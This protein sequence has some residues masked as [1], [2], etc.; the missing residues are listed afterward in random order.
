VAP[1]AEQDVPEL[2]AVA[3]E[4][5]IRPLRRAESEELSAYLARAADGAPTSG[6]AELKRALTLA[7]SGK[8][9]SALKAFDRAASM[10][11][12]LA[13]WARALGA[14]AAAAVGDTALV[15]RL[16]SA[17][18]P[19]LGR[20]WGWR[21]EVV[22]RRVAGDLKGATTFAVEVSKTLDD[23]GRR[24]EAARAAGELY[25][26][27]RDTAAAMTEFRRAMEISPLSIG[28][29]DAA[30]LLAAL[31][32]VSSDD[33]GLVGRIYLRHGNIDRGL[34]YID[35]FVA[36]AGGTPSERVMSRLEAG[37]ALFG[38]GRYREVER[39]LIPLGSQAAFPAVS[40]EALVLVGRAQ[41]RLDR[42]DDARATFRSVTERLAD[43]PAAAEAFYI[44]GDLAHD[45]GR[46]TAARN[47]YKRA[48]GGRP[49]SDAAADAAMR[50]GG[51]SFAS[52]DG[53]GAA[54]LFEEYR[55]R[56]SA[57][58]R[59]QQATYWA[60]RS[61]LEVGDTALGRMRLREARHIDAAS[62]YGLRAAEL[63]DDG[64]WE[65]DLAPSPVTSQRTNLETTGALRRL[66]VLDE[67]G[68]ERAYNFEM[69]RLKR[70]FADREG[71]LYVLAERFL[72]RDET[73]AAVRLGRDILRLEGRWNDRLLR[74]VYPF[75]YRDPIVKEARRRGIDPFLAAGL[76]RQESLF[77]PR[78]TSSAGAIGL[79]Q[80]MPRT[81]RILG[82][83]EGIK[84]VTSR[85]LR[86]PTI[87]IRLGMRYLSD[88][89][90][91]YA[92]DATYMLAAYN[93]GPSRVT[94]WRQHAE[95]ADADLFTERIPYP[96]TRDYVKVV[97]QNAAIYRFLYGE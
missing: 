7:R 83:S 81:G 52:G 50:L 49:N 94:R 40:A 51:I 27:R 53:V 22:G 10:L 4:D 71:A 18:E 39:R 68:L 87:N 72:K 84:G 23:N 9:E 47:Y 62:W 80:V 78:A 12:G 44:L 19:A 29:I 69:L 91:G 64:A 21:A 8:G 45:E 70:H 75:P 26:L 5:P 15:R 60:G 79:M 59:Y 76:V 43:Q 88:L 58:P 48:I 33:L 85:S 55:A 17:T 36:D 90:K 2:S 6:V 34:R 93:A 13:D 63:L 61:Y 46:I 11:P 30:R 37:R 54:L 67:L 3:A 20:E 65:R 97:Q 42:E 57:G 38:A 74:I 24:S 89:L 41:Y 95:A 25:L 56:R 16:L 86:T 14:D 66:D 77:N 92:G 73:E 96:E 32:S 1:A 82:R 31:P 35:Q 28:A